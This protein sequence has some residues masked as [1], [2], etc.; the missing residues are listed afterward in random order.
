MKKALMVSTIIGFLSTFERSDIGILQNMGYEVHIVCNCEI[1]GNEEHIKKL[2]DMGIVKHHVPFTRNPV[3]KNNVSAYKQLKRLITQ[4]RFD[5]IHCHTPVGGFVGR[6][7]AKKCHVPVI[8][9]TAHGFHFY[10]GCPIKNRLIFYP[11]EKIMSQYTDILITINNEDY[12]VASKKF[13]SKKTERIHGVGID[14]DKY[15]IKTH[16]RDKKRMELGIDNDQIMLFS[17]GEL[18]RNKNHIEILN[19]MKFLKSYGYI[20]VIAGE[21]I[22]KESYIKYIKENGLDNNVKILGF[23]NDVPELLQAADIYIFPS[24]R[25]GLSVA[26]ME[27]VAAK[28]PIACSEIRGNVDTVVTKDSYFPTNDSNKLVE[29][30]RKIGSMS[31]NEKLSMI[32]ENYKNLLKYNLS[33]VQKEMIKIYEYAD[34]IIASSNL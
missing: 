26:L 1:N 5:I 24:I 4:E 23:R 27:A 21:G 28:I 10:K 9:Y 3:S 6:M 13:N 18:N 11:I 34:Q 14:L 7:A 33:E 19:A 31:D 25:E 15:K 12:E 2:E 29:V 22:L 17:V 8:I 30:V 32:E 16:C 20:L